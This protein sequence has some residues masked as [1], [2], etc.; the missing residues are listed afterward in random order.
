M[1]ADSVLQLYQCGMLHVSNCKH[2]CSS[3]VTDTLTK[4]LPQIDCHLLLYLR[5]F[6]FNNAIM[7]I[8]SDS[9]TSNIKLIVLVL[10]AEVWPYGRK[11]GNCEP[12]ITD[13]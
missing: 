7:L 2:A 13:T 8:C 12:H 11:V 5:I 3:L 10:Y 9:T 1:C 4:P 6:S